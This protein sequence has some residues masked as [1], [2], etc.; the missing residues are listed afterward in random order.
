MNFSERNAQVISNISE[1]QKKEQEL[2]AILENKNLSIEQKRLVIHRINTFSQLR[3]NMYNELQNMYTSYQDD[4]NG[5]G[6]TIDAQINSINSMEDELNQSKTYLNSL[7]QLKLDKLRVT[8]INNYY[9]KR[10][11]AYKNIMFVISISCIPILALTIL[12]NNSVIPSFIYQMV[13]SLIVLVASYIVFNQ[14]LDISNRDNLNWDSYSWHFN[15]N[16]APKPGEPNENDLDED[17]LDND[18][19]NNNT[20]ENNNLHTCVGADCCGVGFV[21]NS[22][23]NRCVQHGNVPISCFNDICCEAG[24]VYDTSKNQCAPY[25]IC[26]GEEC[27]K[28]SEVYDISKNRCDPIPPTCVGNVCC[29]FGY[30][31]NTS[32]NS[33]ILKPV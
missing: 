29:D 6:S 9:A 5:L 17:E 11:N 16:D 23:L 2:Y 3:M 28:D 4:V 22:S 24:Y 13:I 18:D 1:L 8:E 21:Y 25:K 20:N 14:Y 31:Y 12:N 32:T 7:D 30:V 26:V 19:I 10:Y 33:C 15:K 27:C